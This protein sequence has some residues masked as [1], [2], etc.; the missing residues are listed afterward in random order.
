[1]PPEDFL[2][3]D[4]SR[5]METLSTPAYYALQNAVQ[6]QDINFS[7]LRSLPSGYSIEDIRR[8]L[9]I[10]DV[11][12][13]AS[14][15]RAGF[16]LLGAYVMGSDTLATFNF[17]GINSTFKEIIYDYTWSKN[18]KTRIE[19]IVNISRTVYY[20]TDVNGFTFDGRWAFPPVSAPSSPAF[21]GAP[22]Q[23]RCRLY[24]QEYDE[25]ANHFITFL[26]EHYLKIPKGKI[27]ECTMKYWIHKDQASIYRLERQGP[28][29]EFT[30]STTGRRVKVQGFCREYFLNERD[31]DS[32]QERK[33]L[34]FTENSFYFLASDGGARSGT[35]EPFPKI[36][37]DYALHPKDGMVGE[38]AELGF[39]DDVLEEE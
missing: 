11:C 29:G 28:D 27:A 30:V 12:L 37:A 14:Y 34:E 8:K 6:K 39:M 26:L 4:A 23:E 2:E 24:R 38:M 20:R 13:K 17:A 22:V 35:Y 19:D 9:G 7:A 3:R 18:P 21:P 36:L 16:P 32:L 5:R 25:Y 1:M 31:P 15:S 33:T 10:D